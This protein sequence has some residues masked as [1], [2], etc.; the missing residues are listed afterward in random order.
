LVINHPTFS[1]IA[2]RFGQSN[3]AYGE[4]E[5]TAQKKQ[6]ELRWLFPMMPIFWDYL[7]RKH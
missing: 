2:D 6:P 3:L 5:A 1:T 7:R 4:K